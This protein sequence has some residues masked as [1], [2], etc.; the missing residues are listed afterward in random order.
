MSIE[1][2]PGLPSSRKASR[3]MRV[4]TGSSAGQLS[5]NHGMGLGF[6]MVV[7]S[8][9][10][11]YWYLRLNGFLTTVNFVV[12]PDR[13]SQQETDVDV[14]AVRFPYRAENLTRPM[15]DDQRFTRIPE[16]SVLRIVEVKTEICQL[17][18][19]W[20]NPERQNMFR[21]LRAVG[22]FTEPEARIAAGALHKQGWYTSQLYDAAL[23]C[24]GRH[25]NVEIAERYP[26]VQQVLWGDV[27]TFIH[28]R[29]W[30]Y[31]REKQSHGQWDADAKNLWD[32][33]KR[34]RDPATL[35]DAV[36]VVAP[37]VST[38]KPRRAAVPQTLF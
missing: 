34:H 19:P 18:G 5:A 22:M 10:L 4:Q 11:A 1:R 28:R 13:G 30:G 31:R 32:V 29:F 9:A 20:T 14:L 2:V 33:V 35:V 8:E 3:K 12:H 6:R 26:E 15:E 23:M 21:V 38:R 16:K 37:E 24:F 36:R 27:L 7:S 25:R 17:N